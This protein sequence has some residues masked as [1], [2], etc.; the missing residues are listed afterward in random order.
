MASS[1]R[2]PVA[3]ADRT[4]PELT[5]T[6]REYPDCAPIPAKILRVDCVIG[7]LDVLQPEV[8]LHV[9]GKARS[10]SCRGARRLIFRRRWRRRLACRWCRSQVRPRYERFADCRHPA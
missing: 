10:L 2:W 5:I 3:A 4:G 6:I 9:G 7:G 8:F 1:S